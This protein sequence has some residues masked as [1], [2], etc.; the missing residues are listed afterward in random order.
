[1]T[2]FFNADE[3]DA[4]LEQEFI[5]EVIDSM[6][7]V[8]V[9]LENLRS[10]SVSV[11]DSLATLKRTAHSLVLQCRSSNM[12]LM[13]LISHRLDEYLMGLHDLT[14]DHIRDIQD[15]ADKISGIVRGELTEIALEGGAKLVREL[16]A[17]KIFAPDQDFE[18]VIPNDIEVMVVLPERSLAHIVEREL[19]ACGLRSNAVRNPFEAFEQAVRTKPDLIIASMELG[20]ISGV[21]LACAFA[22]M[23]KTHQIPFALFTSYKWGH[24]QLEALPPRAALLR[25][26]PQFGEDLAEALARFAIT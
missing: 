12:P 14:P 9:L 25:K 1:M 4:L 15:F 10:N 7:M 23:P 18:V 26:G 8:E 21:D 24:P 19:A 5:E 11:A 17:K 2:S 16:P 20:P 3:V 6:S 22:A 13:Q